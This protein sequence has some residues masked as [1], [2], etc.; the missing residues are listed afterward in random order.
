MSY[1]REE[2]RI[3][4][5]QVKAR[6]KPEIL[7]FADWFRVCA[8]NKVKHGYKLYGFASS[9]TYTIINPNGL[10]TFKSERSFQKDYEGYKAQF[11]NCS[12]PFE[13]NAGVG[14][15]TTA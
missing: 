11:V 3:K 5:V 1:T 4:A 8:K 2:A 7:S 10:I 6:T 12:V 15:K 9:R 14:Q 13:E